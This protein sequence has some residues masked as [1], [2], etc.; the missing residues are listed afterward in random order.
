MEG[1]VAVISV[2]YD[3]PEHF[4]PTF[5]ERILKDINKE[6]YFVIR[7]FSEEEGIKDRSYYFKFTYYRIFKIVEF[8]KKNILGKRGKN[9][10]LRKIINPKHWFFCS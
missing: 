1:K 4:T 10:C 3:Y 2:L 6:D 8:I 5:E 9:F 7:Y